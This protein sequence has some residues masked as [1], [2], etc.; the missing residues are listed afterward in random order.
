MHNYNS[1]SLTDEALYGN[2]AEANKTVWYF[3]FGSNLSLD[4]FEKR[5]GILALQIFPAVLKDYELVFNLPGFPFIEPTFANLKQTNG[6]EV[7]GCAFRLTKK[8]LDFLLLT[9]GG[10]RSYQYTKVCIYPYHN[11]A[12]PNDNEN[13]IEEAFTL[14]CEP[15]LSLD[16]LNAKKHLPSQ[17]YVN[18]L[19]DGSKA[20]GL[21]LLFFHLIIKNN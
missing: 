19:I 3:A 4:V 16:E 21:L 5:R 12:K 14:I 20:R 1:S 17:R 15:E 13:K 8:Q 6:K 11:N 9:E 2:D 10:G 7:E 18:L